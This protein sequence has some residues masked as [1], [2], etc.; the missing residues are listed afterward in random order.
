MSDI[1]FEVVSFNVRGIG[2]D[3]KRRQIFSYMKKQTSGKAI[4]CLQETHSILRELRSYLNISGEAKYCSVMLPP[5]A[6]EFA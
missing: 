5:V 4:I 6:K 3:L 2:D 1:E